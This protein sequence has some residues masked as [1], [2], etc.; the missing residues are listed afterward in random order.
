[1]AFDPSG[2][3]TLVIGNFNGDSL[4]A[5]TLRLDNTASGLTDGFFVKYGYAF[6]LYLEEKQDVKCN[7]EET[8]YIEVAAQ[9][10]TE[11]ITY[12]WTPN[13]SSGKVATD[14]PAGDYQI[15]ATGS[16]GR[17]DTLVVTISEPPPIV[18]TLDSI[19]QTSC[20]ALSAGGTKDDG[21]VYL[22][23]SGG[24]TPFTYEWLPGGENIEDPTSLVVGENIVVVTDNNGC[25]V[26]DTFDVPQPDQITFAGTTI[27]I[28]TVPPGDNG[29]INLVTHGGTPGYTYDWSGPAGFSSEEDTIESLNKSGSYSVSVTD[30]NLCIQDTSF[31]LAVD[32]GITIEVYEIVHV[33]CKGEEN[34]GAKVRMVWEGS[35]NYSYEWRTTLGQIIG[36][37]EPEISGLSAG[38]YYIKVTDIVSASVD[39]RSFK[40]KEPS[41]TLIAGIDSIRHIS[42]FGES[43]GYMSVAVSGGW[44]DY[45]YMWIPSGSTTFFTNNLDA[46]MHTVSVTDA[47]GCE[48]LEEGEIVEPEELTVDIALEEPISCYGY[49]DGALEALADGGSPPYSYFWND[50]GNQNSPIATNLAAG[51]YRV[52]V[53]DDRG[54][55]AFNIYTLEEPEV[56]SL[57]NVI[58]Q[59]CSITIEVS[60]GTPD[61]TYHIEG[62]DNDTTETASVP[63]SQYTFTM[64]AGGNYIITVED[65]NSC[66][67]LGDTLFVDSCPTS[68]D[69]LKLG[70]NI[71]LY[72][73]PSN[74]KF[75]IE[76]ENPER[77]DIDLEIINLLGQRVFRQVYES[78]G[79]ARFVKTI[80]LGNQARGAYFMRIN[81]LPVRAKLVIK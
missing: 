65:A 80:D 44:G 17:K 63:S 3:S 43:D 59:P 9:F 50:P 51:D 79:E 16:G 78:Y 21:K 26:A 25:Q 81:G 60:G 11:P 64:L 67:I 52:D 73:N 41:N 6:S 1:M 23:L 27:D 18:I 8:G 31:T 12:E 15:I 14:L 49:E 69:D 58:S 29:A 46:G 53:V 57:V 13:V 36:G 20:H 77:E 39:E 72:P 34:G 24:V 40:I 38:T 70:D 10:G 5:G 71:L 42:C 35:G 32:T 62:G 66:G 54:C 22:S 2:D 74:G 19:I 75:T 61:Y 7:G 33:R 30:A 68:V 55:T 56:F 47:N 4:K 45:T 48:V 37:N 28:I 76:L